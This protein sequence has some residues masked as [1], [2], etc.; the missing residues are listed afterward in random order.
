M[1]SEA[2]VEETTAVVATGRAVELDARLEVVKVEISARFVEIGELLLEAHTGSY[3]LA[4]GFPTFEAWVEARLEMSYRKARY[5]AECFK[6]LIQEFQVP[7]GTVAQLGWTKA[8]ELIPVLK[9]G[10]QFPQEDPEAPPLAPAEN[11]AQW[12]AAAAEHTT[13]ELNLMVREA[14]SPPGAAETQHEEYTTLGIGL[15]ES[16]RA[17]IEE[18]IELAKLEAQTERTGTAL[19]RIC[20]D[21][22]QE[23]R[24]RA[25]QAEPQEQEEGH[26]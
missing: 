22:I 20:Q 21:Y 17:V 12:L 2:P 15:F 8:K 9:A 16:E 3:H 5:L 25:S 6:V 1:S 11:R 13:S 23:A 7:R 26:A 4:L 14:Q 10:T 18:A 19:L 24:A